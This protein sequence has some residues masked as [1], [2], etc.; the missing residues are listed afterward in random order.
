[1]VPIA[2]VLVLGI[3]ILPMPTPVLDVNL[4]LNITLSL[5]VLFVS[6]YVGKPLQFSAYPAILLITTLY[7]LAMN[8][9]ST[10]LILL[11][12]DQGL[13]AAGAII[14]AFGE[15]VVG[16]NFAIGIVIFIPV[17][18]THLRAHET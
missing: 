11:N 17:S 12:G 16:G 13:S 2:L 7:R 10:R 15:F 14:Q 4:A 8:V 18:Y 3:L 1:M 6:I 5:L 9:A